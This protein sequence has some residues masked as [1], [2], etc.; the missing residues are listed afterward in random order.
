MD[1]ILE[2]ALPVAINRNF[3]YIYSNKVK[4]QIGSRVLVNF[5]Q[6]KQQI[7]IIVKIKTTSEFDLKKLKP[8]NKLIDEI[9]LFDEHFLD[10]C[11][12]CAKYY[13]FPLGM[14][15]LS[16]I[17]AEVRNNHILENTSFVTSYIINK[18]GKTSLTDNSFNKRAKKQI[19]L[20]EIL[21][22]ELLE[23][24]I[25]NLG[26]SRSIINSLVEKDLIDK[27]LVSSYLEK[28][29]IQKPLYLLNDEQNKAIKSI[30]KN[31]NNF[32]NFDTTL[33]YGVTGSGKTEVYM[34][35]IEEVL[36]LNK[37]I[38]L[39]IPEISL[40]PQMISRFHIRFGKRVA[41]IHSSLTKKTTKR[42]LVRCKK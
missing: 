41:A 14:V 27:K 39:M 37:Q 16:A 19:Q 30:K 7:G 32:S 4:P 6:T 3:D 34:S 23:L 10:F 13:A 38:L 25:R 20:L 18:K 22:K 33:I 40:T 36:S 5:G 28:N 35:L 26:F 2:I 12:F 21:K 31:S 11:Q 15:F 42:Y 17:P 24:E 9:A 1:Y 29:K 8:I